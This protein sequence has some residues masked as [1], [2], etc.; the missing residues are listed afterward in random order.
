MTSIR[1]GRGDITPDPMDTDRKIREYYEHL[2]AH[3]FDDQ[4]EMN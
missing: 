2:C 1:D 3:K 4:G